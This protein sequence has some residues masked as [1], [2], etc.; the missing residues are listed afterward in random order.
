MYRKTRER[1]TLNGN[2][3]ELLTKGALGVEGL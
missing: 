3:A 2:R 1:N